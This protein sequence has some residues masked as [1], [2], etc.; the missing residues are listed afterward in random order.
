MSKVQVYEQDG[1]CECT[2]EQY[3][4]ETC[5]SGRFSRTPLRRVCIQFGAAFNNIVGSALARTHYS[6][7]QGC[8]W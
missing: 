5:P 7:I 4:S 8:R 1:D 3:N 2:E 6:K